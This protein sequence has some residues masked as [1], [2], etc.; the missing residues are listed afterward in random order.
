LKRAQSMARKVNW[1]RVPKTRCYSFRQDKLSAGIVCEPSWVFP[2]RER[3][4]SKTLRIIVEMLI[5]ITTNRMLFEGR[6]CFH[7]RNRETR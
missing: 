2:Y 4:T 5:L 6:G 1:C 3:A 7:L